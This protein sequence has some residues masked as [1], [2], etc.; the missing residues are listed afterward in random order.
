MTLPAP[1]RVL[2]VD[3]SPFVRRA[4]QRVLRGAAGVSVVGE[5]SD[6]NEA[7]AACKTLS[8]HVVV[9]DISMPVLDG[10]ETLRRLRAQAPNIA[11]VV[12][13]GA[14]Q[15]GAEATLTAIE[16]GAVDFID[17]TSVSAMRLHELAS[18]LLIKIRGAA[19]VGAAGSTVRVVA[20]PHA[21]ELP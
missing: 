10:I 14:V 6:G 9:L 11:V 12:V 16:L 7:L 1:I 8:P 5:A 21:V 3:D 18:E 13:S 2:L 17:K 4:F 15:P 20:A 19:A